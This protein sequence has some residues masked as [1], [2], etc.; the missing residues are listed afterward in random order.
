MNLRSGRNA[1][2]AS[3]LTTRLG[4]GFPEVEPYRMIP[5]VGSTAWAG[6][7]PV[8]KI[9]L[10]ERVGK[11]HVGRSFTREL[12]PLVEYPGSELAGTRRITKF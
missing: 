7:H 6:G 12:S 5:P 8:M 3:R 2:K 11:L 10:L 1:S 9:L 4:L